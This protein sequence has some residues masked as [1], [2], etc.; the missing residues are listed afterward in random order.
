MYKGLEAFDL[1]S[2]ANS[3]SCKLTRR[4]KK[5]QAGRK[6]LH[7]YMLMWVA[8]IRSGSTG[9]SSEKIWVAHKQ[10]PVYEWDQREVSLLWL[11][12]FG[13]FDA[14]P[15]KFQTSKCGLGGGIP[16]RQGGIFFL[17]GQNHLGNINQHVARCSEKGNSEAQ[18]CKY[19][20]LERWFSK[21]SYL[22]LDLPCP[23]N[24]GAS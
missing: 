17:L 3:Y 10:S 18:L 21:Q 8:E 7:T 4:K 19:K 22:S 20:L 9:H 15:L 12:N 16:G 5:K 6:L 1:A 24:P 23:L 2:L 13:G 14:S 11:S